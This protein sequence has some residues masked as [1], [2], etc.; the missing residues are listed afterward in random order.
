[1]RSTSILFA[2]IAATAGAAV[3]APD[4]KSA[5]ADNDVSVT[6]TAGRGRLGFAAIQ[7]SPELRAYF[8]APN[9]RGVLVDS[10]RPD[11]PAAKAGLRVGDIVLAVDN[12]DA[13][14]AMTI[15]EALND[16]KKGDRVAIDVLRGKQ[17][18]TLH[19]TLVDDLGPDI[20]AFGRFNQGQMP[21][22][23][24]M[25]PN[26]RGFDDPDVKSTL[27]DMKKRIEELEQRMNTK[28]T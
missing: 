13:K 8:G 16:N 14:S 7:I 1:M 24:N 12:A 20:R 28:R 21:D 25:F 22:M 27:D 23:R 18:T 2:L 15:L 10:V 26:L 4:P 5:D 6:V 3:A 17:H 11:S 9:D 19:A